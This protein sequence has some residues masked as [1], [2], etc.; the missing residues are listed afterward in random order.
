MVLNAQTSYPHQRVYVLRLH[1]DA[2]PRDGRIIGRLEHVDSGHQ[3]HFSSAEE[4][5][6]CLVGGAA[7][8]DALSTGDRS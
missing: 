1:H 3:F 5:I 8:T 2:S 7:F 6:A 4:L